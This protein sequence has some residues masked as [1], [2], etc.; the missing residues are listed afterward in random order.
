MVYQHIYEEKTSLSHNKI[1]AIAEQPGQG[2]WVATDGGGLNFFNEEQGTFK[3]YQYDANDPQSI[4]S[5]FLVDVL[6]DQMDQ[7]LWIAT[8]GGGLA[9]MDVRSGKF[10]RYQHDR[11]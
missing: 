6:W 9:R 5:N 11:G 7:C 1:N 3:S 4:P 10:K 8:W 2:F